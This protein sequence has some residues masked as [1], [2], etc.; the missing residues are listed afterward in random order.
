MGIIGLLVVVREAE[1]VV[2]LWQQEVH[3]LLG[4]WVAQRWG[5][6][7]VQA[8]RVAGTRGRRVRNKM[9]HKNSIL[10]CQMDDGTSNVYVNGVHCYAGAREVQSPEHLLQRMSRKE[11]HDALFAVDGV[12]IDAVCQ[13]NKDDDY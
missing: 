8:Q 7:R 1:M 2:R 9:K 12:I 4:L 13:E 3:P 10:I 6:G 11:I 5:L